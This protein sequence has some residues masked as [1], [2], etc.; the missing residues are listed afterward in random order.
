MV[1]EL[2]GVAARFRDRT[3]R[4][5]LLELV[6]HTPCHD[7]PNLLHIAHNCWCS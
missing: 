6:Q 7:D 1:A 4:F 2:A 3:M 5:I